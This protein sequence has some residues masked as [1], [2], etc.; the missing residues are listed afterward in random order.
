MRSRMQNCKN[1][2][3]SAALIFFVSILAGEDVPVPEQAR[4]A[5]SFV[6]AIG[7]NIH[8]GYSDTVY[9][10]Y[11]EILKPRLVELGVRHVRDGLRANRKDVLKKLT[12]LAESGIHLDLLL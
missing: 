9:H 4:A 5:D 8:L 7:V 2:L 10:K 11:D 12:D 6:D 3:L 1:F